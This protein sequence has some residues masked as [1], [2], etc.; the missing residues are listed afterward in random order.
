VL[1]PAMAKVQDDAARLAAAYRRGVAIIAL[2]VLP[3]SALALL[4]ASEVVRVVLGPRWADAVGPFQVLAL[5]MLFRTSY[6]MSDSLA[7]S[8]GAVYRR[9]WRQIVYAALVIAGAWL[10]K[11]WGATGVACGVLAAVTV[12]F[13]SMAQLSLAVTR[14]GWAD[15]ARAHL[16]AAVLTAAVLPPAWIAAAAARHAALPAPFVVAAVGTAALTCAG[17]LVWW[18]PATFL[19]RDGLWIADRLRAF[20]PA[21]L[22]LASGSGARS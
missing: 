4:A 3:P 11:G 12:N 13:A 5:G 16:P 7:R 17:A 15:F 2:L 19:G 6:K 10:G 9:A 8:A 14:M 22:A 18:W 20:L 1:F 21:K